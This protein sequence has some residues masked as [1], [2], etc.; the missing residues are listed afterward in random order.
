MP[1]ADDRR[2]VVDPFVESDP[3]RLHRRPDDI[4]RRSDDPGEVDG[5]GAERHLAR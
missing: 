5:I 2:H 4:D 3:F 1:V